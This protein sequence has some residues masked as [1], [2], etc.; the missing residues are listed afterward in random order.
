MTFRK[1]FILIFIL[2][3]TMSGSAVALTPEAEIESSGGAAM[4]AGEL[5]ALLHQNEG[6]VITLT[7]DIE[8]DIDE[9]IKIKFPTTVLMGDYGIYIPK[10]VTFYISGPVRFEGSGALKPLFYID[11]YFIASWIEIAA[12]GDGATAV[13]YNQEYCSFAEIS[14]T[15]MGKDSTA[16]HTAGH[17][18][19]MFC[20][21]AATGYAVISD[22]GEIN[23]D[24]CRVT[25]EP[26]NANVI[27]REAMPG[28]RILENGI[29]VEV[30]GDLDR[31]IRSL[32]SRAFYDLFDTARR[33][34]DFR[35]N[36]E[37]IVEN[38]PADTLVPGEYR[39]HVSPVDLPAWFPVE[40]KPYEVPLHIIAENQPH[41][42]FAMS[43]W[44]GGVW[45]GFSLKSWISRN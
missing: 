37:C 32:A 15:A 34:P 43:M 45:L 14:V 2:C 8:W 1:V 40:L 33:E 23:M 6:G 41:I 20:D 12:T 5:L 26:A 11:G 31:A 3:F 38:I 27:R 13:Y 39:I 30:G 25:P 16:I 42:Q 28:K 21:I 9:D 36:F 35:I 18:S 22:A 10:N 19:L 4:T 24:G 44:R 17:V 7:G 29:C